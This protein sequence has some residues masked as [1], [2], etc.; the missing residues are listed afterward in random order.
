[1]TAARIASQRQTVMDT[2]A[3]RRRQHKSRAGL[4]QMLQ[5]LTV[6]QIKAELREKKR[7]QS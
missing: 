2:I 7:S 1:M 3:R 4:H 5:K 6:K